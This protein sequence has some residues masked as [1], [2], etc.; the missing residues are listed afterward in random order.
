M[1]TKNS[2]FTFFICLIT[3]IGSAQNDLEKTKKK[4][5]LNPWEN[6]NGF[7]IAPSYLKNFEF[8]VSYL[9]SSYPKSDPG[10]GGFAM[11]VQNI[12][13][14]IEYVNA[15]NQNAAGAKFT[16]EVGFS[17]LSTQIGVDYL[18]SD[19]A[20]QYRLMPKIGLSLFSFVNLYYGWNYN[21][22]TDSSLQPP[23]HTISLQVNILDF[24]L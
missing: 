17:L 10:F 22:E 13:I 4:F 18:V 24:F 15:G 20:T 23:R 19:V 11:L 21:L 2:F 7:R 12:G 14:G 5:T 9:I 16:Y 6:V 3:L 1:H 8:E